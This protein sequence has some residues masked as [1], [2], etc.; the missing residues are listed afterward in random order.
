MVLVPGSHGKDTK[1]AYKGIR[2]AA[3][4]DLKLA[5]LIQC[6]IETCSS[7]LQD[8]LDNGPGKISNK[9]NTNYYTYLIVAENFNETCKHTMQTPCD[10][11]NLNIKL[12]DNLIHGVNLHGRLEDDEDPAAVLTHAPS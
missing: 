10:D 11:T 6:T 8:A 2:H 9:K 5:L 3:Q 4:S 1:P 7:S 12:I